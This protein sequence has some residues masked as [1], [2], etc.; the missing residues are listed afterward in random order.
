MG[1]LKQ[2]FGSSDNKDED[3]KKADERLFDTMKFEAATALHRN[4][5]QAAIP[6]LKAAL[7][8]HDDLECHDYLSQALIMAGELE[9]ALH[10]TEILVN[11]EPDNAAIFNR[12]SHIYFMMEDYDGVATAAQ[13]AIEVE[14]HNTTALFYLGRAAHGRGDDVVAVTMLDKCLSVEPH[15]TDALLLRGRIQLSLHNLDQAS[16]D[17][18]KLIELL[19]ESEEAVLLKGH[20]EE[21]QDHTDSALSLYSKAIELNPFCAAAFAARGALRLKLGDQAGSEADMQSMMEADPSIANPTE[22]ETDQQ[23]IADKVQQAYRNIDPFAVF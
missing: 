15:L 12:L 20:I 8:I 9:E 23:N 5:P 4:M 6:R 13:H 16:A 18:D 2:L 17:A 22:G 19:P 11:A 1:F 3:K 7:E 10:E 21:A 14:P